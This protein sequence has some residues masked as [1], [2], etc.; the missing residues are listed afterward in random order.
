MT[1]AQPRVVAP[2]EEWVNNRN[3]YD[4][5]TGRAV[6]PVEP[7][8]LPSPPPEPTKRLTMDLPADLHHRVKVGCALEHVRMTDIVRE[9]LDRRF[10][11]KR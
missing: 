7:P 6:E 11:P 1:I 8:P 3:G 10:P 9:F 2:V 4:D 5:E